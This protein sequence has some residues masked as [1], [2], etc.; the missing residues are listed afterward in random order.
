M[1]IQTLNAS[2]VSG[3]QLPLSD[4]LNAPARGPEGH[5]NG[6]PNGRPNALGGV[7][8]LSLGKYAFAG[9]GVGVLMLAGIASLTLTHAAWAAPE[10]GRVVAGEATINQNGN[11]TVIRA[12]NN[13]IIEFSRYNVGANEVVRYI[14]PNSSSKVLNRIAGDAPSRIDG[15]IR[16]NGIVYLVNEAGIFFSKGSMVDVG[17]ISAAAGNISNR[18]FLRGNDHFTGVRGEVITQGQINARSVALIGERVANSGVINADRGVVAMVSG[19]DV[20]LSQRGDTMT[21][22]VARDH[23]PTTS[24]R[25]GVDNSGTINAQGGQALIVAG[26]MVSLAVRNTGK[27]TASKVHVEA[28]GRGQ[29]QISGTI[30]ASGA[31]NSGSLAKGASTGGQVWITGQSVNVQNA[32]IDASGARAGG[33]VL[34]GGDTLGQGSLRNAQ[35]VTIDKSSTID[36]SAK[37]KGDGGKVVVWSDGHTEFKGSIDASGAQAGGNGGFVETSGKET[38]DFGGSTV[39]VGSTTGKGGHWLIDPGTI[40]IGA[41][42]ASTIQTVLNAGNGST[43]VTINTSSGSAGPQDINVNS[44][45][46]INNSATGSGNAPLLNLIAG[47]NINI[48]AAITAASGALNLQLD[49][50]AGISFTTNGRVATNRGNFV[51]NSTG[52]A[53]TAPASGQSI[54]TSGGS[55]TINNLGAFNVAGQIDASGGA[56]TSSVTISGSNFALTNTLTAGSG[57]ISITPSGANTALNVNDTTGGGVNVSNAVLGNLSTTGQVTLSAAGT[58]NASVGSLG[59]ISLPFDLRI[60]GATITLNNSITLTGSNR[61]LTFGGATLVDNHVGTDAIVSGSGGTLNLL[62]SGSAS[63]GTDVAAFSAN[64]AT[65]VYTID[66]A[67]AIALGAIAANTL[68]INAR[69]AIS[70]TGVLTIGSGGLTART[71]V[72][73]GANITLNNAAS[74][75]AGPVVLQARNLANTADANGSISITS[76]SS[77]NLAGLR[78]AGNAALTVNGDL[79]D[80]GASVVAGTMTITTGGTGNVTLN[81]LASSTASI[82]VDTSAATGNGD[83]TL[84]NAGALALQVVTVKGTLDATATGGNLT[85]GAP[86]S[87]SGASVALRTLTSGNVI[88]SRALASGGSPL[89][90]TLASVGDVQLASGGS[91]STGGGLFTSS[92]INFT[93]SGAGQTITTS[94]GNAVFN[95]TGTI[96]TSAAIDTTGGAGSSRVTLNATDV[97]LGATVSSGTGGIILAPSTIGSTIAIND[98]TGAFSVTAADLLNLNSTGTVTIG[99][100]DGTGAINLGS[101]GAIDLSASNVGD[102]SITGGALTFNTNGLALRNNQTFGLFTR[103]IDGGTTGTDITIGGASGTLVIDSTGAV[104]LQSALARFAGQTSTGN[105]TLAN[106]GDLVVGS[107]GATR[108]I[109]P[110]TVTG[111]SPATGADLSL[112]ATGNLSI[113]ENASSSGTTTLL[114][115][116]DLNIA[117]GRSVSGGTV[118][119]TATSGDITD[120]AGGA[121]AV[122]TQTLSASAAAGRINLSNTGSALTATLNAQDDVALS[123]TGTLTTGGAWTGSSFDIDAAGA[124]AIQHNITS[125]GAAASTLDTTLGDFTLSNNSTIDSG[126]Q[127]LAITLPGTFTTGAGSRLLANS[128]VITLTATD[129]TL[130]GGSGF[131]NLD[132]GAGT[133]SVAIRRYTSGTVGIGA[134]TGGLTLD[135]TELSRVRSASLAVGSPNTTLITVDGVT[136]PATAAIGLLTLDASFGGVTP[137]GLGSIV[138]SG[139]ESTFSALRALADNGIAVN[140]NLTTTNGQLTLNGDVDQAAASSSPLDNLAFASGLLIRTTGGS[141]PINLS[142]RTGGITGAGNLTLD[143]NGAVTIDSSISVTNALTVSALGG[144]TLNFIGA[145]ESVN[146]TGNNGVTINDNLTSSVGVLR[147]NSDAD[148]DGVG[149]FTLAAGRRVDTTGNTLIIRGADVD[150]GAGSS[151]DAG[152]AT[153][154]IFQN[155]GRDV[156]LGD[157]SGAVAGDLALSNAEL[158]SIR[159]GT[160]VIGNE[161]ALAMYVRDVALPASNGIANLLSLVANDIDISGTGLN[162]G[163]ASLVVSRGNTGSIALGNTTGGL[164]LSNAELALITTQNLTFGGERTTDILVDSVNLVTGSGIAGFTNLLSTGRTTFSGGTSTFNDL[165]VAAT[166]GVTVGADLATL[167]TNG[168]IIIDGDSNTTADGGATDDRITIAAGRTINASR[169]L[170]LQSATNGIT[171]EGAATLIAGGDVVVRNAMTTAGATTLT[172]DSDL[173]GAGIVDLQSTLSTTNNTLAITGAGVNFAQAVSSGTAATTIGRSTSGNIQLGSFTKPAVTTDAGRT[174]SIV[175]SMTITGAELQR[176]TANGLTLG[177]A[178]TTSLTSNGVTAAQSNNIAGTTTLQANGTGGA[179]TFGGTSNTFNALSAASTSTIEATSSLTTDTGAMTL[180]SGSV[181]TE[182][183]TSAGAL[184]VNAGTAAVAAGAIQAAGNI[185]LTAGNLIQLGSTAFSSAGAIN[186]DAGSGFISLGGNVVA[187][188]SLSS[189]TT[190]TTSQDVRFRSRVVLTGDV[191]VVANDITFDSTIN[192][193][194]GGF[195]A[196]ELR[197][198]NSGVTRLSGNVGDTLALRNI[199]TSADGRSFIGGNITADELVSFNDAVVLTNDVTITTLRTPDA[200]NNGIVF[201]SRINSDTLGTPRS[202]TLLPAIDATDQS[203]L[204]VILFA[205]PIGNFR[206]LRDLNLNYQAA[207]GPNPGRNGRPNVPDIATIVARTRNATNGQLQEN[208]GNFALPITVTGTFRMGQNEKL[209]SGGSL[210]INAATA[211]LGDLASVGALRVNASSITLQRRA[212]GRLLAPD[213][214]DEVPDDLQYVTDL[215]LDFVAGGGI[216]FTDPGTGSDL[217]SSQIFLSGLGATPQFATT[218]GVRPTNLAGFVFRDFGEITFRNINATE[219]SPRTLDLRSDGPSVADPA[220]T[221]AQFI[222]RESRFTAVGQDTTIGQAQKS[223]LL[224]LKINPRDPEAAEFLALVG[225]GALL[226]DVPPLD[227]LE[228]TPADYRTITTRLP[229]AAVTQ[230]ITDYQKIVKKDKVVDGEIVIDSKTG[231]PERVDRIPEIKSAL[232]KSVGRFMKG[233]KGQI[234]ALAFREYLQTDAGETESLG[235]VRQFDEFLNQLDRV[236]LTSRELRQSRN[237]L[238]KAIR[239]AGIQTIEQMETV[240]RGSKSTASR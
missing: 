228:P 96:V 208:P 139:T 24:D 167:G 141:G 27:V 147:I 220:S 226:N 102:L 138:F 95:H 164:S 49:A 126:G 84:A 168:N 78:T 136:T 146:L 137:G 184:T 62:L 54:T 94:G 26:D 76:S 151:I 70:N 16:A 75:F 48:D 17:G 203:N 19:E 219:G 6:R 60:N 210:T 231:L 200:R 58:G 91:V 129:V 225:G 73:V 80:S 176:L 238:L 2:P 170:T 157:V 175:S 39:A 1:S 51:S 174:G 154:Q 121:G 5:P 239:P 85:T 65:G 159:A 123:T 30:D 31:S 82:A 64:N 47:D 165:R 144:I 215:G 224:P 122:Q 172:A 22:K 192:S 213:A 89:D 63:L 233:K 188:N 221:R 230:L 14:Q 153:V 214:A 53:I 114:A 50:G 205:G 211:F 92:G 103:G 179:I 18:D 105:L 217:A 111:A 68:T 131:F 160:L 87:V 148:N 140:T 86:I 83:V 56:G 115:G 28:K 173:D 135:N 40:T 145:G 116:G 93:Q 11:R 15:T 10:G 181:T 12:G 169:N 232:T 32:T 20:Y 190:S 229:S 163:P 77:L 183:V 106:T 13:S 180:A 124:V 72:D 197:S 41:S 185:N 35:N 7:I 81:D 182:A 44:A 34:I 178:T 149:T 113:N 101:L 196:L 98:A 161:N 46:T 130:S 193:A 99:R 127:N 152:S 155:V 189:P 120:G 150:L 119:L 156:R 171:G 25:P 204:A 222:P 218:N 71:L 236:G 227:K 79:T 125:T 143:S 66:E 33:E 52:F 207:S 177:G 198:Q 43:V 112:N 199:T 67:N 128:G 38:I 142:A 88:L 23:A 201:G 132:T 36:A 45:I 110:I 166:S 37:V 109:T 223:E 42:E 3:L 4:G 133:G 206:P 209:V 158:S 59:T 21:V 187:A 90:V 61:T 117:S 97:T 134:G 8:G 240:V 100:F 195:R 212:A 216:R 118:S 162:T 234:D 104:R 29:V 74:T 107:F 191:G 237:A 55:V 202:L 235:Y 69:G 57:G 108:A 194:I 9:R 186:M